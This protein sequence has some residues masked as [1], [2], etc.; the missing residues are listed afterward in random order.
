[1]IV[2]VPADHVGLN[3]L[4]VGTGNTAPGLEGVFAALTQR[5]EPFLVDGK[6]YPGVVEEFTP[7]DDASVW[8]LKIRDGVKFHNGETMTA[9][10][11]AFSLNLM[12]S[13]EYADTPSGSYFGEITDAKVLDDKTVEVTFAEPDSL[14]YSNSPRAFV[15]PEAYYNEVGAEGFAEQPISAGPYK[16]KEWRPDDVLIL[17]AFDDY[18]GGV[19]DIKE[20][21]FRVLP[22]EAA[23]VAALRSGDIDIA[24]PLA[25]E[26]IQAVEDD[27][28]LEV[29]FKDSLNRMYITIDSTVKPFDNRDVRLA[30]NHAIDRETIVNTVLE[31]MATIIPGGLVPDLEPGANTDLVPYAYDPDL[32]KEL[33]AKAGY[34]NGLE[35][36][37]GVIDFTCRD[38]YSPKSEEVCTV[39]GEQLGAIGIPVQTQMMENT[40]F[41]TASAEKRLPPLQYSGHSGGG[42]FIGQHHLRSTKVCQEGRG[43][44][45]TPLTPSQEW[46]GW[47]CNPAVDDLVWQATQLW[48]IDNDKAVDLIKQAEAIVYE[49]AAAGFLWAERTAYGV[50]KGLN[51]QPPA[52]PDYDFFGASWSQ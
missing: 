16:F 22:D 6:L 8:T 35:P 19:P 36:E 29:I 4:L 14:F 10:D 23:R 46:G 25:I 5:G 31:G 11:V 41:E 26:Q 32:A 33:L 12:A 21:Q 27:P 30:I 7:N 37:F 1:M 17:E 24:A 52:R 9:G 51:W 50:K 38:G 13:E 47:Y 40:A 49:D 39:I 3:A 28:N 44:V 43:Q 15:I 45:T 2:G 20:V 48:A 34:P 42:N 18:Y